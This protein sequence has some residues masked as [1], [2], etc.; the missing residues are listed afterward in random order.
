MIDY[1]QLFDLQYWFT[2]NPGFLSD[3]ATIGFAIFFALFFVAS[4]ALSMMARKKKIAQDPADVKVLGKIHTL[5]LTMGGIGYLLLFFSYQ[6]V[7]LLSMRFLYLLWSLGL[8][9][10]AYLIWQYVATEVPRIKDER[11]KKRQLEKYT[12]KK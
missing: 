2:F 10:W 3:P 8:A 11:E 7:T 6:A 1:R 5:L 9:I 12:L 4:A